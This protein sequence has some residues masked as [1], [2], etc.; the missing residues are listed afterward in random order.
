MRRSGFPE[1]AM[2]VRSAR[3]QYVTQRS[4]YDRH[5]GF[6][7]RILSRF[8][9]PMAYKYGDI[10]GSLGMYDPAQ[11]PFDAARPFIEAGKSCSSNRP[12]C[13][14]CA[15]GELRR[16][17]TP[18]FFRALRAVPG[19]RPQR[20]ECDSCTWTGV[21]WRSPQ[22]VNGEKKATRGSAQPLPNSESMQQQAAARVSGELSTLTIDDLLLIVATSGASSGS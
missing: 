15:S 22:A 10:K 20:Y 2:Q 19:L 4:S 21:S 13:H 8:K 14:K 12:H 1:L 16:L 11:V 7:S 5:K 17:H 9:E 18:A 6:F 3:C